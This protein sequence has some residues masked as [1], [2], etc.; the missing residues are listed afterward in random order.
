M[1]YLEGA[2]IITAN[3]MSLEE[4]IRQLRVQVMS[5]TERVYRL[6]QRSDVS[7]S[8][9]APPSMAPIEA[10]APVMPISAPIE[11]PQPSKPYKPYVPPFP[12]ASGRSD[13]M[14]LERTIGSQWLNRVGIIAVLVGVSYFLKLASDNGWI[15][16]ALRVLIGLAAGIA[17][18]WWSE[19]F[20]RTQ[21]RAF[22]YSLKAIGIG[23]LY[24]SLW[25]SFQLYQLAP[26]WLVFVA[27]V[28]VTASTAAMALLQHSELLAGLALVGGYLTPVLLSTG[29][30][31]EAV[32][33][34]YLALLAAGSVALQRYEHWPR[35]VVGAWVGTLVLYIAWAN[36]Y[37]AASVLAE[38][39]F[40]VTLLF[41]I[42]AAAPFLSTFANSR[43]DSHTQ[44]FAMLV[45]VNALAYFA[46]LYHMH[47]GPSHPSTAALDA[48]ILAA[49]YLGLGTAMRRREQD[50]PAGSNV[51]W[52]VHQGLAVTFLTIAIALKLNGSWITFGWL[53][54]AAGLYIIGARSFKEELKAFAAVVLAL[55]LG[56]IL[57]V[58]SWDLASQT[59]LFNQR[60]ALYLLAIAV[61]AIIVRVE[62]TFPKRANRVALAVVVINLLAVFALCLEVNDYFQAQRTAAYEQ[63]RLTQRPSTDALR[64]LR[65]EEDF[66]YSAVLMLYGVG[67]MIVGFWKRTAF[68]RWQAIILIGLTIAKVF[69]YDMSN[70]ERIYRIA[71]FIILGVILLAIS[72][73]Y[74]KDWLGLQKGQS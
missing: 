29:Q 43:D 32:L 33:L 27:M 15:G 11:M 37:Y 66:V 72:Y 59:L 5:L 4:E 20:R 73:A 34:T 57:F 31:N 70:L 45:V 54:E 50:A 55:S 6:E 41:A 10:P 44:M 67:L 16:P 64:A 2:V 7:A 30:N 12:P 9:V 39:T 13:P 42:F 65:I 46:E 51:M 19:R 74:Q 35:I 63:Q 38:T 26:A 28:L 61:L 60:F 25:A 40:F 56:R 36:Q 24:L 17:L 69:L 18:V 68:L 52:Q 47:R 71:S 62:R 22:S 48:F 23:V 14:S 21:A 49:L 1:R 3:H 53:T 8:D 58:D